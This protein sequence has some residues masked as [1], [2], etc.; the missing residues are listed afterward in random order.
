[1]FTLICTRINGWVNNIE[2]GDLRRYLP[3]YGVIVM[4]L[5]FRFSIDC[6]VLCRLIPLS[7]GT[8]D[9]QRTK[10]Q[11]FSSEYS[12]GYLLYNKASNQQKCLRIKLMYLLLK[13][14]SY[15]DSVDGNCS[16]YFHGIQGCFSG[17]SISIFFRLSC[18]P[19]PIIWGWQVLT[20][21]TLITYD[22]LYEI[23]VVRWT[24]NLTI[25]FIIHRSCMYVPHIST[26]T[27]N[28]KLASDSE[29]IC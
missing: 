11:H 2:A 12:F 8:I 9:M 21:F 18:C 23:P 24:I 13:C 19:R 26:K 3:H 5:L 14:R 16:Y 27:S 25:Q 22:V 20:C 1:M 4:G 29:S 15:S 10:S 6:T 28:S 17:P 7:M